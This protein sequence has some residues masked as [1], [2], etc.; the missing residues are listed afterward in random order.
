[1]DR[2]ELGVLALL[3]FGV[4]LGGAVT[5]RLGG[6]VLFE[7]GPLVLAAAAVSVAITV[8]LL[9]R[10][11]MNWRGTPPRHAVTAAVATA[12]PGLFGA[13]AYTLAFAPIT[14]LSPV[15]A[16]PY[17]ALILFGNAAMLMYAVVVQLRAEGGGA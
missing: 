1:M 2:R 16:G 4:W 3:G 17:A 15:N 5:F 12:L 6:A 11:I 9:L 13:V 14:G 10:S 7:N 8:C